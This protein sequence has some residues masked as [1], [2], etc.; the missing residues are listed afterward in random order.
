MNKEYK[1]KIGSECV[2]YD[3]KICDGCGECMMCDLDPTKKCDNCGK[4]LEM[5]MPEMDERG[6]VNFEAQLDN[7]PE[8]Q[9]SDELNRLLAA[10]GLLDDSAD[11]DNC[12]CDCDDCNSANDDCNCN[13]HEHHH[14]DCC[15]HE[16]NHNECNSH[17]HCSHSH[18]DSHPHN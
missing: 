1:P 7:D 16:H 14:H 18:S 8:N 11:E 3:N 15:S 12:E 13:L 9:D 5:M 17:K 6:F 4:C 2:I 10:Y